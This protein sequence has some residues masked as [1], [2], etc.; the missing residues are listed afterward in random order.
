MDVGSIISGILG[1]LPSLVDW[2]MKLVAA[3]KAAHPDKPHAFASDEDR[4]A[5][6]AKFHELADSL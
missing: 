5:L 3:H 4:D 1:Q 2:I 6:K